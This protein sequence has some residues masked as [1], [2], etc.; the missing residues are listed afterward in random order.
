MVN[1]T[2]IVSATLLLLGAAAAIFFYLKENNKSMDDTTLLEA[3]VGA[4]G[5]DDETCEYISDQGIEWDTG[6]ACNDG[7]G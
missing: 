5:A 2:V 7:A 1:A 4:L 3:C 6:I